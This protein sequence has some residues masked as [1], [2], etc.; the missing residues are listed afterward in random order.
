M[1]L[2]SLCYA[3]SELGVGFI[4]PCTH[5]VQT[6]ADLITE[7]RELAQAERL[8]EW[9]WGAVGVLANPTSKVHGEILAGWKEFAS[10]RLRDCDLFTQHTKSERSTLSSSGLLRLRWPHRVD[11]LKAIDLDLLLATP[12]AP[13]LIDGRY[14][15]PREI[16]ETYARQDRPEYFVKNVRHR[17]RTARDRDI[18]KSSLRLKPEWAKQYADVTVAL[19]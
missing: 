17:I 2:S 7:A 16:G 12:T 13:T 6:A 10:E 11:N 1:V 15:R 19:G 3:H 5:P 14:P 4:V 8:A 18:W 9:T